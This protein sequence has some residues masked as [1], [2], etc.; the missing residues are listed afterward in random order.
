MA[1]SGRKMAEILPVGI[2]EELG[3]TAETRAEAGESRAEAAESRAE[4]GGLG[5]AAGGKKERVGAQTPA[6][7]S[8][9]HCR[10]SAG[11]ITYSTLLPELMMEAATAR[12]FSGVR[13][14]TAASYSA[15]S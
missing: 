13:A 11:T 3:R 15:S 7:S 14:L 9:W 4:S 6:L 2:G 1:P 12:T 10:Y 5:R 8:I